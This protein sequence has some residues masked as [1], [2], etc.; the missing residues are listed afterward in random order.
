MIASSCRNKV[1]ARAGSAA[2]AGAWRHV[3]NIV[4]PLLMAAVL[5]GAYLPNVTRAQELS[6]PAAPMAARVKALIPDLEAYIESAMKAYDLP[7]LAIGI[8]TGDR[9]VYARGFGVRSKA[10][11]AP[12]DTR[13]AFQIGS[14]TKGFLA[15][16]MAIMVDRGKVH[17]DDRVVD[18]YPAFQLQDA[19][20]TREFRIFDLMAQRSGLRPLVNDVVGLLGY[21]EPT[22]IR[23][24][25]DVEPVSSFRTTFAYTNVTHLLTGRIVASLAG[26]PDWN[27]VAQRELLDPLGMAETSFTAEAMK[28][29]ANRAEGHRWTPDGTSEVSVEPLFPYGLGAAGN[30]NSTL[31]DMARWLRLQLA[32][33][34]FEGRRIVSPDSLAYTR[35]PKVAVEDKVSYAM[36]WYVARTRNGSIVWHDGDTNSYGAFLGMLPDRDVGVIVLT[37]EGN[38]G[39]PAAIGMWA[40]DRLL[41]NPA[42]DYIAD[43]LKQAKSE[44]ASFEKLFDKPANPRPF[45]A[46]APL[47][48][49]VA[50]PVFG[51]GVLRPEGEALVLEFKGTGAELALAPWDGDVFTVSMLPRGRFAPMVANMGDRLRGFAQFESGKDGKLGALRLTFAADGQAYE[52]SRD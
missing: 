52:F 31:E 50:S 30:I 36:G 38:R 29:A 47:A 24:L 41:D 45:P 8:V 39:L 23:S 34:S 25:R 19:W 15:T 12:V 46:L 35:L 33:G 26:T 17:W 14:L 4:R 7:G 44:F 6:K 51:K 9:L 27:A 49:S 40:L 13:T 3:G 16:T 37:N 20:V 18:L 10:G 28:A 43:T 2:S 11:G 5:S 32:N 1:V 22:M 42:V 21:A 48:G